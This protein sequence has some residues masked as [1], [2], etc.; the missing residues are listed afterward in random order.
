MESKAFI[1]A[2]SCCKLI[3]QVLPNTAKASRKEPGAFPTLEVA[4]FLLARVSQK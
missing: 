3:L 2:V 1:A 4:R